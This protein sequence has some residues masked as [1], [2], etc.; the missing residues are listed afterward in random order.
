M[1]NLDRTILLST[2][3][4]IKS[5]LVRK[6]KY[7]KAS[8][9]RSIEVKI[10]KKEVLTTEEE[11]LLNLFMKNFQ[12][13]AKDEEPSSIGDSYKIDEATAIVFEEMLDKANNMR[14]EAMRILDETAI[15]NRAAF[16]M[17]RKKYP[18]IPDKTGLY[19]VKDSK[20]V[21]VTEVCEQC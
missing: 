14:S 21:I 9:L 5:D 11:E 7:Q 18:Q 1:E 10:Y 19:Y 2:I 20:E 17:V 13:N 12:D 3:K 15:L 8:D 16:D 4:A 6:Q